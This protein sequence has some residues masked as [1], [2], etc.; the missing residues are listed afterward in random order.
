M[1]CGAYHSVIIVGDTSKNVRKVFFFFCNY[2]FNFKIF[3]NLE[4]IAVQYNR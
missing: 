1:S 4:C 3:I 2:F